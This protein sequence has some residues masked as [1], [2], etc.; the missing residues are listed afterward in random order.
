MQNI[1]GMCGSGVAMP[2]YQQQP[3]HRVAVTDR[4]GV[5]T[6]YSFGTLELAM[7]FAEDAEGKTKYL[8]PEAHSKGGRD[9]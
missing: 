8:G 1:Q 2:V 4:K 5:E 9:E 6:V 7:Q 3:L